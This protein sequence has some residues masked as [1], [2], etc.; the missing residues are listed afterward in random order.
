MTTCS[1][2]GEP[3]RIGEAILPDGNGG[4]R[5]PHKCGPELGGFKVK[6]RG[7]GAAGKFHDEKE[8]SCRG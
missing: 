7:E 6:V 1:N 2:C 3:L 5:H 4:W 8:P